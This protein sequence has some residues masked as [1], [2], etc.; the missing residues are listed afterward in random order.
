[1]LDHCTPAAD[2]PRSAPCHPASALATPSMP[3]HPPTASS[4]DK[5]CLHAHTI[6]R[7]NAPTVHRMRSEPS[8][9]RSLPSALAEGAVACTPRP[10]A[11]E[12][13]RVVPGVQHP[14]GIE[15]THRPRRRP[16]A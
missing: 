9:K 11:E 16:T 13:K 6:E 3:L 14:Q 2:T 7:C 8:H 5:P 4:I 12:G 10:H 15:A 1:M